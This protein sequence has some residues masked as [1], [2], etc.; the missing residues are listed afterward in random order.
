[1]RNVLAASIVLA[2]FL[3]ACAREDGDPDRGSTGAS[4]NSA[5]TGIT[6]SEARRSRLD[7]PLLVNGFLVAE[8]SSVRICDALAESSPP[9]CAGASL[10]VRGLDIDSISDVESSGTVR[11]S[12]QPRLL[13]GE[14]ESGVL[15][16]ATTNRG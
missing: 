14:V 11:W 16:V 10:E 5:G 8:D 3:A 13:L 12:T 15:T 7:G 6:V 2:T 4:P 1:M 9:R